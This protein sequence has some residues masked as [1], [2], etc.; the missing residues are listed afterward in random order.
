LTALPRFDGY[1]R[2]TFDMPVLGSLQAITQ[3]IILNETAKP[4][5]P[6]T[7]GGYP[8][9]YGFGLDVTT[10]DKSRGV[11]ITP[12]GFPVVTPIGIFTA[13]P[14]FIY[15]S[16]T[17]VVAAPYSDGN[18]ENDIASLWGA[19]RRCGSTN[20]RHRQRFHGYGAAGAF[21]GDWPFAPRLSQLAST[22]AAILPSP[23]GPPSSGSSAP[24]LDRHAALS[25][26]GR[27]VGR[28]RAKAT[29]RG[30]RACGPAPVGC[31][32]PFLNPPTAKITV[33]PVIDAGVASQF[34][35]GFAAGTDY[36]PFREFDLLEDRLATME[37]LAGAGAGAGFRVDAGLHVSVT[38]DFPFPIGSRTFVNV[39]KTF[40]VQLAGGVAAT[41]PSPR[42]LDHGRQQWHPHLPRDARLPE[43]LHRLLP[44]CALGAGVHRGLLRAGAGAG[45]A[46]S[47]AARPHARG[48]DQALR[49]H[50]VAV[51]HL[52][53][54]GRASPARPRCH[55][56]A[57]PRREAEPPGMA[58]LA[59]GHPSGLDPD[60]DPRPDPTRLGLRPLVEHG[61]PTCSFD[62]NN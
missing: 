49:G 41:P 19:H 56:G 9:T 40:T 24:D 43:D 1:R 47:P 17:A 31:S 61:R 15:A 38:A 28:G 55:Q 26:G 35:L 33:T 51:Q 21:R 37:I 57:V 12:P 3:Q 42:R 29:I 62:P 5:K 45:A 48:S 50:R 4:G 7:A 11:T 25:D 14:Q 13:Q 39:N 58:G 16:R 59:V 60:P 18:Q 6:L 23:S 30:P 20:V 34:F 8:I 2:V 53:L 54:H 46:A 52:H 32:I 27:A 22:R 10:E 44:R 36:E